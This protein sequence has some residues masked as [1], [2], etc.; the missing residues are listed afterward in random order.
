MLYGALKLE[1][2]EVHG[3]WMA[4]MDTVFKSLLLHTCTRT[5]IDNS[6]SKIRSYGKVR[7]GP[8]HG[9]GH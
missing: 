6:I 8:L 7:N 2:K 1:R 4:L 9:G 5:H 3:A